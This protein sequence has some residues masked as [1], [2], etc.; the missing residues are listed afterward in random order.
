MMSAEAKVTMND[1]T[2]IVRLVTEPAIIA[3]KADAPYKTLK[4]FIDAREE[5]PG[6]AEA[7]GRIDR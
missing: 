7:V 3:V 2:P 5:K 6:Q 1:L 4:D